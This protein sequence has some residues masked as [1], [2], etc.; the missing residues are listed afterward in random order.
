MGQAFDG[1]VDEVV[2]ILVS[3]VVTVVVVVCPGDTLVRPLTATPAPLPGFSSVLKGWPTITSITA[4]LPLSGRLRLR[5]WKEGWVTSSRL[6][7]GSAMG[8]ETQIII[9]GS[10]ENMAAMPY[11]LIQSSAQPTSLVR[12]IAAWAPVP[13]K[14]GMNSVP[15]GVGA[16]AQTE[17][18]ALVS[19]IRPPSL[20]IAYA[21][22]IITPLLWNRLGIA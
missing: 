3:V 4:P 16:Q 14:T 8:Y 19:W 22:T 21:L 10:K 1:R 6:P 17:N 13:L 20:P 11:V 7:L 15:L 2:V 9:E 12:F 5:G 18:E